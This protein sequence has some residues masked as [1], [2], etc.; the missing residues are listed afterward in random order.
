MTSLP[1]YSGKAHPYAGVFAYSALSAV[2]ALPL[3]IGTEVILEGVGLC[4]VRDLPYMI[5]LG[6]CVSVV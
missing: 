5:G 2:C 1:M 3:Y 6:L 4:S